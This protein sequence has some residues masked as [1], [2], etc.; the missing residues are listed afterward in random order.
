[1]VTAF[2]LRVTKENGEGEGEF[3]RARVGRNRSL[4]SPKLIETKGTV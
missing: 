4:V 2:D 1:M 3:R